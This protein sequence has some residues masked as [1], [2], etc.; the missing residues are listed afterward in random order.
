MTNDTDRIAVGDADLSFLSVLAGIPVA[1]ADEAIAWYTRFLGRV[2]D[3]QPM[4]GVAEWVL[5]VG[6]TLQIVHR[7]QAAG[8]G[9]TRLEVADLDLAISA[10]EARGFTPTDV[11]RYE[12]IVRYADYLD[13]SGNEVSIVEALFDV[14]RFPSLPAG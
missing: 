9:F 10:I 8:L 1:D 4:P 2:P 7:P 3:M 11:G 13:P 14:T 12:G 5:A 6:A